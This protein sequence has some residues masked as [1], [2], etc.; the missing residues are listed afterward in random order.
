MECSKCDACLEHLEFPFDDDVQCDQC[1]CWWK[2]DWDYFGGWEDTG[3]SWWIVE[4]ES[5]R[6]G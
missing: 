2:T 4:E 6:G 5:Q 3:M 1:K